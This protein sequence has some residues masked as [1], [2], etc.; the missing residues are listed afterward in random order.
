MRVFGRYLLFQAVGWALGAL[1]LSALVYWDVIALWLAGS[2]LALLL[3]KDLILFPYVRKAYEPSAS[4][5]GESLLGAVAQVEQPLDPEG[6]VRLGAERWRARLIGDE[7][8]LEIGEY[9]RVC[10]IEDLVLLVERAEPLESGGSLGLE[11]PLGAGE[12]KA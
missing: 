9:V 1:V 2:L 11:R 10:D 12:G 5:G 6:W 7:N 4:H 3:A 8:K